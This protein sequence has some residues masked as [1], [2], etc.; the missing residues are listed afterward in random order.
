MLYMFY[1]I[2]QRQECDARI[3]LRHS[4]VEHFVVI[5]TEMMPV[6]QPF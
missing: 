5:L 6:G 2:E 4:L 1:I 3:L